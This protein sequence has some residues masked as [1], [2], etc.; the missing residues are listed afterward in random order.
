MNQVIKFPFKES[1]DIKNI[2]SLE[3]K[4]IK[5]ALEDIAKIVELSKQANF[6]FTPEGEKKYTEML[7][8]ILKFMST[9]PESKFTI[10]PIEPNIVNKGKSI[11]FE[12]P[13]IIIDQNNK[14]IFLA[15]VNRAT[16]INIDAPPSREVVR[17][18]VEVHKV[19]DFVLPGDQ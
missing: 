16:I 9:I 5:I 10:S 4:E 6:F 11:K 8:L 18:S 15:I 1:E 7:Y 12:A 2:V 13:K 3:D 17:F 19:L 14:D